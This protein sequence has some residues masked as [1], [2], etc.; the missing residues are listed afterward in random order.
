[1]IGKGNFAKVFEAV[2]QGSKRKFA[3]K[4]INKAIII[5]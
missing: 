5:L 1:M 3:L 2:N 4:T